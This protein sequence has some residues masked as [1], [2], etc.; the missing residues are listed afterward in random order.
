MNGT[1]KAI[2]KSYFCSLN[3]CAT[4]TLLLLVKKSGT[5]WL[6]PIFGVALRSG[7]Q[8]LF[9]VNIIILRRLNTEIW[10][11]NIDKG[12]YKKRSSKLS[13]L[14]FIC[15]LFIFVLLMYSR[16]FYMKHQYSKLSIIRP[17]RCWLLEF[18]IEIVLVF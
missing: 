16:I 12:P 15:I 13:R 11:S 18:E 10:S 7:A 9:I 1:K 3:K 2:Q 8:K 6:L 14:P 17:G 4:P 5:P